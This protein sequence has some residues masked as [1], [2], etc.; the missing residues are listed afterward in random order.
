MIKDNILNFGVQLKHQFK[1]QNNNLDFS[2]S[3]RFIVVAMGGSRLAAEIVRS[4]YP[5]LPLAT[6][7]DYGLPA[8]VNEGDLLI[9]SSYSG[10]TE[11]VL[12]AFEKKGSVPCVIISQGGKLLSAAKTQGLPFIE[13]PAGLQPR[14]ATGYGI[15][16]ILTILN[17]EAGLTEL[18]NLELPEN[19]NEK[20]K[21]IAGEL[22]AVVPVIHS[23]RANH[24][25]A[26][27]WRAWL[28]ETSKIPAFC[29][30][31]PESNH[32]EI[33][34]FISQGR[35]QEVAKNFG[36]LILKDGSDHPGVLKRMNALRD[37][38]LQNNFKV[39]EVSL[40]GASNWGKII[41]SMVEAMW[42][43]IYLAEAYGVD[44]ESISVIEDFKKR[45]A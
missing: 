36:F 22:S 34:G 25:L 4:V 37:I 10:N 3:R 39:C 43:A 44:P 33:N 15:K 20:A 35:A 11:E 40:S 2:K 19:L 13:L 6:H 31:V 12:D 42:T 8:D 21:S 32:N 41:S 14:M 1:I 9:F 29:S 45:I 23:S 26:Y 17:S 7:N 16:A 18:E 38:Y 30:V 27:F 5:S 28:N 24:A